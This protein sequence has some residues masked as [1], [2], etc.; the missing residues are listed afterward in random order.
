MIIV[1]LKVKKNTYKLQTLIMTAATYSRSDQADVVALAANVVVA[2]A[3]KRPL[4]PFI[5]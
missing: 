1:Q 5:S 2:L 3:V 4:T